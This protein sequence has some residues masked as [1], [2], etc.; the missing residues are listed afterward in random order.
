VHRNPCWHIRRDMSILINGDVPLCR[1][2]M[3]D[4]ICGNIFKDK[5]EDIWQKGFETFKCHIRQEYRGL[6]KNCDEYYTFN[7]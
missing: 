1:E 6:C 7:F 2:Y 4:N 3:F 5:I